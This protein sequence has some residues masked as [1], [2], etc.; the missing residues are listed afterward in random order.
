MPASVKLISSKLNVSSAVAAYIR[1]SLRL[2][3]LGKASMPRPANEQRAIAA[4][5]D[6]AARMGLHGQIGRIRHDDG[7]TAAYYIKR[8]GN[9]VV[10]K[11]YFRTFSVCTLDEFREAYL[12]GRR[13]KISEDE[14]THSS[15]P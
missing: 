3:E 2:A 4:L 12:R 1:A 11:A 7:T 9:T 8:P 10:W 15:P 6:V 13:R 5:Q 14:W